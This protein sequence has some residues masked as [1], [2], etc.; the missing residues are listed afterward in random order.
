MISK[1][2]NYLALV[3][4]SS[5]EQ[6]ERNISIPSQIDQINN[7][8]LQNWYKISKFYK[9][10]NSAYKWKRKIFEEL[11]KDL[12]EKD[13]IKWLI[14]FKFDRL[15]RNLDD[16]IKVDKIIREKN[17]ELLSVTE[18][19]L[20]SYLGRYMVR[21]MQ[22]RAILYSEE[23]SFRV[24]LWIR[25]KLQLWG[26]TGGYTFFGYDKINQK[27]IPNEKAKIIKD[28]FTLYS[29]W[30]YWIRELTKIIKNKYNLKNLPKL[31]RILE[32]H[33]Y[34]WKMVKNWSLSNEEYIF[35]WYDKAWIY[36]EEYDLK[37]VIP[38]VSEDLF[39]LCQKLRKERSSY[40][41]VKN[42]S[43]PKIFK[44]SCWRN[45]SRDDKK[46]NMYLRC[47]N[48]IN[49][50]F[51]TKCNQKYINLWYLREEL[52]KIIDKVT[53]NNWIRLKM[54]DKLNLDLENTI[55]NKNKIINENKEK[56]K[57][58]KSKQLDITNSF[59][60]NTI[61]KEIFTI[62]SEKINKDI[63]NINEVLDWLK[64]DEKYINA[65][66]KTIDFINILEKAYYKA[67]NKESSQGLNAL[68]GIV[69]NI[70]LGNKKVLNL[71]I[72]HPFDLLYFLD[73]TKW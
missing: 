14:V 52:L 33:I 51:Q 24:K 40:T 7:Y 38:I 31:E 70:V 35:W 36:K 9:E 59:I 39:N 57:N 2:N 61:S 18:P 55:K 16:F 46:Q 41:Q 56:L 22:N 25:K 30:I 8:C 4:V 64:D 50:I 71:A 67:N 60:D 10:E 58:L 20:N 27:F 17:I 5:S 43:Y 44:C 53:L 72:K 45:L 63:S 26:Y 34:I 47:P 73:F 21:D 6:A 65:T 13:D 66:K 3:R 23:L 69:E 28:I 11:L 32:N 42:T 1:K 37:Y 15:S 62:S 12:K 48:Q 68:F 19:M 29:Y 49:S 54:K